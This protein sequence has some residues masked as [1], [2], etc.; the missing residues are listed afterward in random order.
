MGSIKILPYNGLC[1]GT[2]VQN[3]DLGKL[4]ELR[5]TSQHSLDL[6]RSF[7]NSSAPKYS[8]Y[9]E[10]QLPTRYQHVRKTFGFT[11]S[12]MEDMHDTYRF[13][14]ECIMLVIGMEKLTERTKE[15]VKDYSFFNNWEQLADE[16]SSYIFSLPSSP[17]T[18][19]RGPSSKARIRCCHLAALVYT[20]VALHEFG[21][22]P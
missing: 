6:S 18:C 4:S 7:I 5:L 17:G 11:N 15:A 12:M 13:S 10:F 19:N 16:L 1:N 9:D 2:P 22:S 20:Y 14:L 3:A 8:R 21:C